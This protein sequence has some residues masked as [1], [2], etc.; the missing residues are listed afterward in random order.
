MVELSATFKLESD[1]LDKDHQRLIEMVNDISAELDRGETANC[2]NMM[3]EFVSFAKGHFG[4]EEQL[5][6]KVGYPDVEKHHIHHQKLNEK[7]DH[8]LEF[9]GSVDDN[10]LARESLKKE[11][12]FFLMDDVI[13]TDLDFKKFIGDYSD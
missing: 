1:L 4:R 5:L 3:S 6:T 2:Q 13:T 11:L 12:V 10:D 7:M 9:A 8:M